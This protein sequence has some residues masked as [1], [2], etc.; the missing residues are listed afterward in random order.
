MIIRPTPMR[1]ARFVPPLDVRLSDDLGWYEIAPL[2]PRA[3]AWI[4]AHVASEPYQWRRIGLVPT[5]VLDYGHYFAAIVEGMQAA[6]LRVRMG[7]AS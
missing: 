6:G 5:L 2:S 7:G 1:F 3:R 4:R